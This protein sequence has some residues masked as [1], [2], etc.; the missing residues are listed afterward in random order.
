MAWYAVIA[1]Q[2]LYHNS[3]L[4]AEIQG[5]SRFVH[6]PIVMPILLGN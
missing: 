5:E 2:L 1:V 3:T 6:T 4:T